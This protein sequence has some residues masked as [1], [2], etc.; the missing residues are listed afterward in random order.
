[1]KNDRKKDEKNDMA[2]TEGAFKRSSTALTV[3]TL[4][5][6]VAVIVLNLII[7]VLGDVNLW[8]VDMSSPKYKDEVSPLYTVSDGLKSLLESQVVP[9]INE[10]NG[11]REKNGE[12]PI[13]LKIVFCAD[14]DDI[15]SDGLMRYISY[16][17]RGIQK[18]Y[19]D[20]VEVKYVNITRDPSAVQKYKTT[21]AASIYSSD[22]ILEF[23]TEYIIRNVSSFFYTDSTA[24]EP[25]AYNGEQ[26]LASMMLSVTRAESPVCAITTNH[27]ESLFDPDGKVKEEYSEFIKLIDAAGYD[28]EFLDLEEQDIPENCRMMITFDPSEDFKAYGDLGENNVSEIEKLDKYIDASNAFFYICDRDTPVLKNLEE[29]LTEWGIT[30]AGAYDE[31]DE[32]ENY[33]L[34]DLV[35]CT[36]S[37]DVIVGN[38]A[39]E[40][41]GATLTKDMRKQAY[42]AKVIFGDATA[43]VPAQNYIKIYVD[44]SVESGTS[45][46]TYYSYYRN[47]IIRSMLDVFTSYP[48]AFAE[49]D[50]NTYEVATEQSTFKLMTV[51]QESRE[52][53]ES[54]YNIVNQ[55]SYVLA[56]ASTDFLANDVLSASSYGNADVLLSALR[57]ISGEAVP[58][59]VSLKTIYEY[60]IDDLAAYETV[61]VKAWSSWLTIAPLAISLA[62]GV[63]VTVRR[64]YR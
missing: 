63:V 57:N 32:Y 49:I 24:D 46:Y 20:L 64:K 45:A 7:S 19:S 51:T 16:T 1:M 58:A 61:D 60:E 12:E 50:G 8:Y 26:K 29:Y 6:V 52:V 54:N 38:Y 44:E 2:S 27:G 48:T 10:I 33:A 37:G 3:I 47:G 18:L 14:R 23:G 43:I 5:T 55:S 31:G 36:D 62:V 9:K 17:A 21:S 40:G 11:Q 42:P 13:K 53:Q 22:V 25:W 4:V 56:L 59:N 34:K 30:V 35:N 39:V 41:I 15:E 28:I